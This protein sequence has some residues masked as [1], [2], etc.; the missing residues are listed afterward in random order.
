[1]KPRSKN[2]SKLSVITS[3]EPSADQNKLIEETPLETAPLTPQESETGE[4]KDT[5]TLL[6]QTDNKFK[7]GCVKRFKVTNF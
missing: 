5:K 4:N 2:P 3:S 7:I 6:R 1:M